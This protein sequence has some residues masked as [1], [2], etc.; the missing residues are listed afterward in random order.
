MGYLT[1]ST[2]E[3]SL[4]SAMAETLIPNDGNGPDAAAA[5]VV[6]FIDRQLASDYGRAP[7]HDIIGRPIHPARTRPS[8]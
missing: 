1:L 2:T 7:R 6:Y 8:R 3:Q 4:L 5:G